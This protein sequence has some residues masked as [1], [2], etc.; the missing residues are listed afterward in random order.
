VQVTGGTGKKK[1]ETYKVS[2]GYKAFYLGEGE[3]SYAGAGAL[4]RAELAGDIMRKRLKNKLEDL[5]IDYIGLNS[6]HRKTLNTE[7]GLLTESQNSLPE[8]RLRVAGKAKNQAEAALI[9]EE[10]EALY[11]NGP[12]GGGGVR[13]YVNEMIGI[14]SILM[15]RK[16]ISPKIS[17]FES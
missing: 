9:G 16:D 13:K 11:T 14:V 7:G 2:V 10:V 5:K 4:E 3:I 8:I 17:L 1:P 15:P 6:V 12:A